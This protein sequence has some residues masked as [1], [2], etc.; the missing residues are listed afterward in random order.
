MNNFYSEILDHFEYEFWNKIY[1]FSKK[2]TN[3]SHARSA[4]TV[5]TTTVEKFILKI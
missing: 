5:V 1:E 2:N 4:L 3:I